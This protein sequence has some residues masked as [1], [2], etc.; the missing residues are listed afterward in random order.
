MEVELRWVYKQAVGVGQKE[1]VVRNRVAGG[2]DGGGNTIAGQAVLAGST[3]FMGI[4]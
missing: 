2:C 1:I 4:D 3:V